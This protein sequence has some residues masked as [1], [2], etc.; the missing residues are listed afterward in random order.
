MQDK[1]KKIGIMGGTFDPIHISHLILGE[2]AYEQFGLDKVL[3]LPAGNPPHKQHR[4]GRATDCQRV[5]MVRRAIEGNDHFELCLEEMNASGYSYTYRT[6]ERLKSRDPDTD[7]YFIIG[8]DSLFEF[9]H[10]REP[11]RICRAASLLVAVR[12][13]VEDEKLLSRMAYLSQK[14]NGSFYRLHSTN[15]DISSAMIREWIRKGKTIRYYLPEPVLEY[16]CENH[17]YGMKKDGD[18][19]ESLSETDGSGKEDTMGKHYDLKKIEKKLEKHLDARRMEHTRGVMYTAACMAMVFGCD[20]EQ[21][22]VAGLLHDCAKCVPNKKK[23]KLCLE[24]GIPMSDY[25]EKNPFILHA[26]LG[27]FLASTKYEIRDQEILDAITW[28]TTGRPGMTD[29]EKIIY[30][31]DYIEPGRDKASRLPFIRNLAFQD[32]DECMYQVLKDTLEYLSVSSDGIDEL[33]EEAY[34]YYREIH[35]KRRNSND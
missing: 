28:H 30:L 10:W 26:K 29:L 31:A 6:L 2:T 33:T 27:A 11:E 23:L 18:G 32:L 3:F 21:A 12:D 14:M 8:A 13:H 15:L 24:N 5:E 19:T 7:Y 34:S 17:I 4:E 16:I 35:R 9:D 20:L 1:K 22:Q 25:E